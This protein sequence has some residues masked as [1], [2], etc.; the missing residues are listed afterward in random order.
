MRRSPAKDSRTGLPKPQQILCIVYR[1]DRY[2]GLVIASADLLRLI[3]FRK[4]KGYSVVVY[5]AGSSTKYLSD[6]AEQIR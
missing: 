1:Y 2:V 6:R 4:R 3:P 5:A